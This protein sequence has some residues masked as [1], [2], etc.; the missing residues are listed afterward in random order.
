MAKNFGELL[1]LLQDEM[2]FSD[3][4]AQR[5]SLV[6][7]LKH[8]RDTKFLCSE[9]TVSMALRS[10][11]SDYGT[12]DGL[13]GDLRAINAAVI[14]QDAAVF[15]EVD[16]VSIDE[17][18]RL[19][20]HPDL[21]GYPSVYCLYGQKIL[22]YPGPGSDMT[23]QLDIRSDCGLDEASGAEIGAT[24]TSDDFTNELVR[25]GEEMLIAR[26]AYSYF[27]GKGNGEKQA[28]QWKLVEKEA[29][30]SMLGERDAL[31]LTG[32]QADMYL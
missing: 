28:T 16:P 5:R 30:Q 22:L 8:Y 7:A 6:R 13:P 15:H 32:A 27:L 9:R 31:K 14:L 26:A 24:S 18:R 17:L 20:S 23:L 10:G 25:R 3:E 21:L 19:R 11:V 1:S 12:G 4:A 29:R 2:H